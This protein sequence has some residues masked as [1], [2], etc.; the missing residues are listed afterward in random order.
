LK[1]MDEEKQRGGGTA[2]GL[3]LF[4][5]ARRRGRG[6]WGYTVVLVRMAVQGEKKKERIKQDTGRAR[7]KEKRFY[8]VLFG[9][10]KKEK[11]GKPRSSAGREKEGEREEQLIY[12]RLIDLKE[13][14]GGGGGGGGGKGSH[15]RKKGAKKKVE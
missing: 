1:A 14:G 11:K 12:N 9:V 2:T 4:D 15:F 5:V 13:R 10:K 7:E 8:R 3:P 6:N